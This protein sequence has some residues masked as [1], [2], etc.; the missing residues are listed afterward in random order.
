MAEDVVGAGGLL[1]PVGLELGEGLGPGDRLVHV[2]PL[3]GVDGDPD[4]GADHRAGD[5]AAAYV[6][7]EIGTHLQLDLPEPVG[8]G[9]GGEAGELLVAVAEPAGRGGVGG[10][11]LL[12]EGLGALGGALPATTQQFERLLGVRASVR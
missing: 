5:P 6:V 9:L 2:P 4:V 12:P 1:D 11:A 8:D 7:R 3:V 10:E